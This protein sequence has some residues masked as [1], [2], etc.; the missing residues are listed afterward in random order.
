MKKNILFL[1]GAILL[2][3]ITTQCKK[4]LFGSKS[5]DDFY[6]L[7]ITGDSGQ[8]IDI[9]YLQEE[10][11][12]SISTKNVIYNESITLP[13]FKQI[14]VVRTKK[15]FL[16][17]YSENDSTTKAIIFTNN[18][19]LADKYGKD[20]ALFSKTT[21]IPLVDTLCWALEYLDETTK[22]EGSDDWERREHC[23]CI[24]KDS[25]LNYL[26]EINYPCYLEFK[27]EDA[28]LSVYL[29]DY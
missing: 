22:L 15:E 3:A 23:H 16:T 4:G 25:V 6:Y 14:H 2:L 20:S 24:T 19:P 28:E 29:N 9:S 26:K 10:P 8:S 18:L 12:S 1:V 11:S 13:Y 21:G 5:T 17:I 27:K 7:Y